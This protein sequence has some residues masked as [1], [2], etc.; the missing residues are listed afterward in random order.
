MSEYTV[1]CKLLCDTLKLDGCFAATRSPPALS[2][3]LLENLNYLPLFG[4]RCSWGVPT[5][6]PSIH[7]LK[8]LILVRVM[9]EL[10]AS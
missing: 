8:A 3:N 2:P 4:L 7:Y 5:G 10:D 6:H 9:G 1:K